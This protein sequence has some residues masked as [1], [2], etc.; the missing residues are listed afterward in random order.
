[1]ELVGYARVSSTDQN[2]RIQVDALKAAGCTKLFTEKKSGTSLKKR[3]VFDE[4]MAYLRE[5]DTLVVTRIDRLTRSILDLQKLLL[6]LRKKKVNLKATEQPVDT[7]SASGKAFLDMLGVFAEFETN[8][9]RERQLEGVARAKEE[10][11]YKGRKPT[12]QAKSKLVMQ[13][14]T[15]G[16]TR[17][18]V[19]KQLNIG[20]ASVYRILKNHKVE[21]MV[22]I[23]QNIEPQKKIAVIEVWLSIE[24]NSKFVRGKNKSR[25]DIE[26]FCFAQYSMK[27]VS[28]DS[29][30]YTL[31]IPYHTDE[32]LDEIIDDIICEA[33]SIADSR[34]GFIEM[35]VT[36]PLTG[37][38]W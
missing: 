24:N 33:S 15:Q 17:Q 36:E 7:G 30:D 12:A 21:N 28:N 9:R 29:W 19:A 16:L 22:G 26:Q 6:K 13:L 14:V 37:K 35:T 10:G 18:I 34:N 32:E 38:A 11:K 25:E 31:E 8:L 4:C 27:K 3:M 23:P 20:V 2:W 5:G 1:M